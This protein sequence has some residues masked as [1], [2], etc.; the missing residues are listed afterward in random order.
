MKNTGHSFRLKPAGSR[1][2]KIRPG[3]KTP[4]DNFILHKLEQKGIK[5]NPEADKE[6]LLKRICLDL[7]GLPPDL[8]MMDRFLADKSP[9][10]YEK[11]VDELM[12]SPA[13]GEKMAL[14]WLDIARYA[15]SHGYQ[16]DNYRTQWPWRDWV[17]HAYNEN[18]PYNEFVTWQLAGD[19]MPNIPKNNC[20]QPALTGTIK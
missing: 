1:R 12:A 3:P 11:M 19:L 10:A 9:N 18:L 14:H 13:Y 4:I 6:R 16:D 8:A 15:D 7:T 17:I 5:P 20:W 2:L